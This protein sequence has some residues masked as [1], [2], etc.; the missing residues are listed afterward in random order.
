[1]DQKQSKNNEKTWRLIVLLAALIMLAAGFWR[2]ETLF[3]LR[4]AISICL[5][6]IGI[7]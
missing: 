2:D 4:R 3:V 7:G 6:C 1:M 5:G